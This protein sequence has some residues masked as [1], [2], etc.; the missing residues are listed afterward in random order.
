VTG[1]ICSP[2]IRNLAVVVEFVQSS[3]LPGMAQ[4]SQRRGPAADRSHPQPTEGDRVSGP[5]PPLGLSSSFCAPCD[6][7]I[8]QTK[9]YDMTPPG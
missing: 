4:S 9:C 2:L 5:S 6:H 7:I 1:A 8:V 3:L